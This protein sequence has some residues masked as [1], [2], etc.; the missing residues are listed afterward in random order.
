MSRPSLRVRIL[1]GALLW[2]FGLFVAAMH[3]ATALMLHDRRYAITLHGIVA[4]HSTM[5]LALLLLFLAGGFLYV[6]RGLSPLAQLRR[7]LADVHAGRERRVTGG[8]PS[9]V[10]PLVEDLNALLAHRDQAVQRALAKAGDL[11]HGLKTPLA[12][13][14]NEAQRA[15]SSGATDIADALD[16][17]IHA[18]QRQIEYHL[19]HARAAASGAAPG[20]QC[21]LLDSAAALVRTMERLHASRGIAIA[22]SV[23]PGLIPRVQ[24]EDLDEMLG[25]L[26]DNACKWA[27]GRVDVSAREVGDAIEVLVDDDGPGVPADKRGVVLHRGVRADEAAPGS[28]LGLAIVR[29]LADLYGGSIT[30]DAAPGGG[31]RARLTLPKA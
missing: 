5:A 23:D 14:S 15:R 12:V 1:L 21:R 9:E 30:L 29:D 22:A 28:G 31:L 11:A 19:A 18:M 7:K 16:G 6:N 20:A 24:R 8:Y 4:D 17:Q 27:R 13:L 10:Q 26:L 25:N 2:S 3:V